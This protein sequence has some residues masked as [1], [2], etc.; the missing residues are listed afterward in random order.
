[1]LLYLSEAKELLREHVQE[2]FEGA[3]VTFTRQSR[4]AKPA[5]PLVSLTLGSVHRPRFPCS[6]GGGADS[7]GCYLSRVQVEVDLFTHGSAVEES[8]AVVAYENTA[9]DDMLAFMDYLDSRYT[10]DWCHEHDLALSFEG[11]PQ[12]LTGLLNDS[13]YEY[14]SRLTLYLYFTQGTAGYAGVLMEGSAEEEEDSASGAESG[15]AE[16]SGT[17]GSGTD[18][19][20]TDGSGTDESGTD[21]SG[22]E[23]ESGTEEEESGDTV[24]R[25]TSSGGGTE[26]LAEREAGYFTDAEIKEEPYE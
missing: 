22:A 17:D 2:Y 23:A 11:D 3:E 19:S 21:S 25:Q 9:M 18:S 1:M 12:D 5:L 15:D 14:R 8:G 4:A 13:S 24:F 7:E 26:E 10:T 20:G 6:S 16:N